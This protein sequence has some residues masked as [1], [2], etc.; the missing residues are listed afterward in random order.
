MSAPA[1]ALP[2]VCGRCIAG[3][4]QFFPQAAYR[5]KT[6]YFCTEFCLNAFLADPDRFYRLHRAAETVD[7]KSPPEDA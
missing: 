6:V 1:D 4:P 3:E 5:G 7:R 2:M